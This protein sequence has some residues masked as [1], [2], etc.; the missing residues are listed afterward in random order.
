MGPPLPRHRCI[1]PT[2]S[3]P[4][5]SAQRG[6]LPRGGGT[7]DPGT[8]LAPAGR[9]VSSHIGTARGVR[10]AQTRAISLRRQ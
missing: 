10:R 5:G 4:V 9:K 2:I 6:Y 7:R 1:V 8:I 3:I